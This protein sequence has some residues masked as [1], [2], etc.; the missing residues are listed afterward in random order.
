MTLEDTRYG[1]DLLRGPLI[2][3]LA[4]VLAGALHPGAQLTPGT[5]LVAN[6]LRDVLRIEDGDPIYGYQPGAVKRIEAGLR[7]AL[8][9]GQVPEPVRAEDKTA[10]ALLLIRKRIQETADPV[11]LAGYLAQVGE[12][13]LSR[14]GFDMTERA[15]VSI[16]IGADEDPDVA[17]ITLTWPLPEDG[18]EQVARMEREL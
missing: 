13:V 1:R 12:F 18:R 16:D 2:H 14:L 15:D 9:S 5:K 7:E 17:R 11:E 6:R 10:A 3:D 8:E 4:V